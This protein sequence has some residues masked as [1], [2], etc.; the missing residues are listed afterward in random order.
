M[1]IIHTI[2]KS[3]YIKNRYF[4]IYL[5]QD[6]VFYNVSFNDLNVNFVHNEEEFY[7]DKID[8]IPAFLIFQ[9]SV[10][11]KYQ[12]FTDFKADKLSRKRRYALLYYDYTGAYSTKSVTA[13]I[14]LDLVK[15]VLKKG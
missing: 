9:N 4:K 15:I 14:S 13:V 5:E 11:N 10:D 3:Y 1:S 8:G 12:Y 6:L 2:L 7:D